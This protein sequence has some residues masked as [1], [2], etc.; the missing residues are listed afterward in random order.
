M[1]MVAPQEQLP[2]WPARVSGTS[3]VLPHLGHAI[4]ILTMKPPLLYHTLRKP[5]LCYYIT[6]PQKSKD[7]YLEDRRKWNVVIPSLRGICFS[8]PPFWKQIPQSQAPSE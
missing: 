3:Y 1:L 8:E 5:I 2:D 6:V 4:E 7:E